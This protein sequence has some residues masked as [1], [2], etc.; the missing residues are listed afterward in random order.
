MS[1]LG[2][3][4]RLRFVS[5]AAE[6]DEPGP[7]PP[8]RGLFLLPFGRPRPRLVADFAAS[9]VLAASPV[10]TAGSISQVGQHV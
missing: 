2:G 3:L 9:S 7:S 4:P 8:L 5:G 10:A 1:T 6:D